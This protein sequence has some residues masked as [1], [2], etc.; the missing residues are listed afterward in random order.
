MCGLINV[1]VWLLPSCVC[2]R[3]YL[4]LYTHTYRGLYVNVNARMLHIHGYVVSKRFRRAVRQC[5]VITLSRGFL[6]LLLPF[7]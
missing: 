4:C 7:L 2:A 3:S 5:I 1:E 6:A